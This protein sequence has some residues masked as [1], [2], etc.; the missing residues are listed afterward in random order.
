MAA[1]MALGDTE[2]NRCV[3]SESFFGVLTKD[4]SYCPPLLKGFGRLNLDI[5]NPPPS[6]SSVSGS[7]APRFNR[8]S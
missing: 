8:T 6:T 2:K 3:S 5:Q 1:I 7:P 4:R